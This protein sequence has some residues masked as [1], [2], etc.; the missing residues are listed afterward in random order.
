M[1]RV[2]CHSHCWYIVPL[3][4][5]SPLRCSRAPMKKTL[6]PV[7]CLLCLTA[8]AQAGRMV[9]LGF[10]GLDPKLT[11][12]WMDE[13]RLPNFKRLS[14]DGFYSPLGTTNP[15]QSPVAWSSFATGLQP[16][17][18]GIF[19]F[20]HRDPETYLPD[21]SISEVVTPQSHF[22]L[23][24]LHIPLEDGAI[25]NRRKGEPFWMTAERMGNLATVLRV[26]VTFPPDPVHHMV[27]GMGVPDL[28]GSQG[29]YTLYTSARRIPNAENGG[30][31]VRV[32]PGPM[33][34]VETHFEGPEH[35]LDPEAGA[36]QAALEIE[37]HGV[38]VKGKLDGVEFSLKPQGWSDWI[39]ISFPYMGLFS[40][41]G[42]VRLHLVQSY[43]RLQLYV[44]PIHID[45]IHPAMQ[46]TSPA[47]YGAE[48]AG[49]IGRFHTIGMP[50]ETWSLNQQH[51]TD[52]A[53]LDVIKTT[54]AERE[55]MLHLALDDQQ[56]RLV[57]SVFVQ[58]DR[59]SH[60]FWRGLDQQ[61]PL[62]EQT[63]PEAR[64]AILW[65]YQ[66][67]DR[68]L[69]ETRARLNDGDQLMVLSDHGF[70]SFR[71]GVHL[72][73]W[74]VDNGFMQLKPDAKSS[75]P[76]FENVDWSNT[77]AYAVGLNGLFINQAGRESKGIVPAA[78]AEE[79]KQRIIRELATLS[80]PQRGTAMISQVFDGAQIYSGRNNSA[81]PDLVPGYAANYRAS[82]QTTLGGVPESLVD[83][84]QQSWSGDHCIDPAIV[85][86]VL[87]ATFKPE[88]PI[89]RIDKL[90]P[91]ILKFLQES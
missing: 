31:V 33:G 71:H 81:A 41:D 45:P 44:T 49:E 34:R 13:G 56:S 70:S 11:Q 24:G 72:N 15:P 55:A 21:F 77:Q 19:D 32:R 5:S 6:L 88:H 27:S 2:S 90:K 43:P 29:T 28:L 16:G 50:E 83:D 64:G 22:D 40:V 17:D 9:V 20:L 37:P 59:V 3:L 48:L 65:I 86:G 58:T 46:I 78:E 26:P 91:V 73:R 74:L 82:W 38:G 85:P 61:H 10:D 87:F 47:S 18:H 1:V 42:M 79:V 84:N 54:L 57:V 35:P 52:Q 30:R 60:M 75:G 69:G 62:Y 67:A 25:L 63:G 8:H 12:Q 51:V 39:P 89:D 14:E 36:L 4:I 53:F 76:L 68:I 23:F 80:D 66:E 7:L